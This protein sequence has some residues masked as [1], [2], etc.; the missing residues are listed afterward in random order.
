MATTPA[1]TSAAPATTSAGPR[2]S[3]EQLRDAALRF[4]RRFGLVTALWS[5]LLAATVPEAADPDAAV[6]WIGIGVLWAWALASQAVRRPVPWW[7]GWLLMASAMELLGPLAGTDGWALVGGASFIV[8]AGVALSGNRLWVAATVVWLSIIA[9]ARGFVAE[10]WNVGGGISTILIFGFGA[11]ALTW[12]VD[13]IQ[14][15]LNERDRLQADLATAQAE[16]ARQAE[17]AESS[18]RLHDTVLQHLTAVARADDLEDA[19]QHAGR[20]QNELRRFLR[21][22]DVSP[23]S[24]R[25]ALES[26]AA[27]AAD[28]ADLSVGAVGDCTVGDRERLLLD[29]TAEA[30]RNAAHHASG[31]IRVF[32]ESAPDHT[33]V[34]V[35]DRGPGFDLDAI[36]DDRLGVRQS[37]IGRLERA[38][39]TATLRTGDDGSEWELR[40]PAATDAGAASR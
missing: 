8:L 12:L 19:R 35:S 40:L 2:S 16:A 31:P 32:A 25:A 3:G 21:S 11:L 14:V 29:A 18:A 9:V 20:A 1:P 10:G 6:M 33:T 5:T 17:R 36:P 13:R 26:I 30:I 23:T 28:G 37:I 24:L 7:W 38:S 39:G 27:E 4:L 22:P 34:W 15:S